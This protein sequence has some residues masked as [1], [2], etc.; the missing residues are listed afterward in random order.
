MITIFLPISRQDRIQPLVEILTKLIKRDFLIH[1]L[2]IIDNKLI[3]ADET[4]KLF[5]RATG[6]ETFAWNT[7]EIPSS[8]VNVGYRRSR[9]TAVFNHAQNKVHRFRDDFIFTVEDD[10]VIYPNTL[11][12]LMDDWRDLTEAGYKIGLVSGVQVGRWGFK[13][14][15]AWHADNPHDLRCLSTA[16]YRPSGLQ[17]IDTTGFYCFLTTY[18]NFVSVENTFGQFGPDVYFGLELRK[19]GLINYIDWGIIAGHVSPGGIL[20]PGEDCVIVRYERPGSEWIRTKP[21][22]I[23]R[24]PIDARISKPTT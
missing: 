11:I 24:E 4:Q 13:Y 5:Q 9:I 16:Q 7:G 15:G 18:H 22:L 20:V 8:E 10:T 3:D 21:D 19:Q 14:V 6:C 2:I 1:I 17:Q 23:I 12:R